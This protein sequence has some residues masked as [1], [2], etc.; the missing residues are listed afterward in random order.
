MKL[1]ACEQDI[2]HV[3]LKASPLIDRAE[4]KWK[5][6][7]ETGTIPEG[8][9]RFY[10]N[11]NYFSPDSCPRYF[12]DQD[13]VLFSYLGGLT[14]ATR[15]CL[16]ETAESQ[17]EI[18]DSETILSL[19]FKDRAAQRRHP[20]AE[21]RQRK[22]ARSL[23]LSLFSSLDLLSEVIAV[24]FPGK[25]SGLTVGRAQFF[26]LL[27]W[28]DE[29]GKTDSRGLV[30]PI[31]FHLNELW[32]KLSPLLVLGNPEHDWVSLLVLFRNKLAHLGR[33][34]SMDFRLHDE[35]GVFYAFLP[36]K[37]P[38]IWQRYLRW[39]T[40]AEQEGASIFEFIEETCIHIDL[41]ELVEGLVRRALEVLETAYSEL[42]TC[43]DIV[44]ELE[45]NREAL[46]QLVTSS[47][48]CEFRSFSPL[49]DDTSEPLIG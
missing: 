5:D 24:F 16:V 29:P 28:F 17:E 19:A 3:V 27:Q 46:R 15:Q 1:Q 6:A 41:I 20:E 31:E 30:T 22:A 7:R 23:I 18:K 38:F 8:L 2:S 39:D 14:D 44:K 25:I 45:S 40:K 37:W 48:S 34:S 47:K 12:N 26:R 4:S 49:T 42:T 11:A 32:N 9:F 13:R 21:D 35:Q 36:R 43:Y 33:F 10:V